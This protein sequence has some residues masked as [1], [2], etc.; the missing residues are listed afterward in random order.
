LKTRGTA[1]KIMVEQLESP[2]EI[3][4][5]PVLKKGYS[6]QIPM[7]NKVLAIVTTFATIMCLSMQP[8]SGHWRSNIH[9]DVLTSR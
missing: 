5:R 6:K 1:R 8:G 3:S 7:K 9:A 2:E 4:R